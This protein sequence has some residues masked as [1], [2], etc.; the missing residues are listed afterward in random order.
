MRLNKKNLFINE[1]LLRY[2]NNSIGSVFALLILFPFPDLL[3]NF[4]VTVGACGQPNSKVYSNKP[5]PVV[6][7][8]SKSTYFR[9]GSKI[10]SSNYLRETTVGPSYLGGTQVSGSWKRYWLLKKVPAV[11]KQLTCASQ[12]I[13]VLYTVHVPLGSRSPLPP[14]R[15]SEVG[16]RTAG[17]FHSIQCRHCMVHHSAM[18]PGNF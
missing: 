8:P 2:K 16:K 12:V 5:H 18:W 6:L 14:W 4:Q 3:S 17:C 1:L 15:G 10:R 7:C 11:E 13:S 9:G